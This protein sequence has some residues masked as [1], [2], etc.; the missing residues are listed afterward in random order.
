MNV[1]GEA[2]TAAAAVQAVQRLRPSVLVVDADLPGRNLTA[3]LSEVAAEEPASTSC[4]VLGNTDNPDRMLEC[5]RAGALGWLA[6][7]RIPCD[8]VF[9]AR[10]VAEGHLIVNPDL[11][12]KVV[13]RLV[14][15]RT[16]TAA[17]NLA[18]L[19]RREVEVL[20]LVGA[21]LTNPEIAKRLNVQEC[22]IKSH[23][24]HIMR[25]MSLRDRAA[26]VALA[27]YSGLMDRI[28]SAHRWMTGPSSAA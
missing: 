24:H 15:G 4:L 5:I 18:G 23:V 10:M 26:A 3:L 1:V 20:Q 19:T 21:G 14:V 16:V 13:T 9:A 12:R 6:K 28:S 8:L 17:P 2:S 11:A 22:T 27:H 25:K 7:E